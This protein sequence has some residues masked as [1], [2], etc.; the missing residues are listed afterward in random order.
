[1]TFLERSAT[2]LAALALAACAGAPTPPAAPAAMSA[3]PASSTGFAAI[4]ANKDSDLKL[5]RAD[6][7]IETGAAA[8]GAM[9]RDAQLVLWL[10]GNQDCCSMRS[11]RAG[12]STA[13]PRIRG[14]PTSTRR[15]TS[16]TCGS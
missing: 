10:A 6:G 12:G 11:R 7:R 15:S 13:A 4:P 3:A 16:A 9:Q 1:M 14:C 8:L 5:Y 2:A